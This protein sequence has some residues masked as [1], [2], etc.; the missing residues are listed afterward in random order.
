MP[1]KPII[2][3][4]P[5]LKWGLDFIGPINP[6]SSAGHIF[7]PTATSYFTKWSKVVPLKNTTDDCVITFLEETLLPRFDIP[8]HLVSDN[9]PTFISHKFSNFYN[10]YNIKH[11][12]PYDYY[13]QGN[14]WMNLPINNILKY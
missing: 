12:F 2:A 6:P 9:L 8:T 14:N 4:H 5:F 13:P 3:T 11:S 7:I 10:K 1:L